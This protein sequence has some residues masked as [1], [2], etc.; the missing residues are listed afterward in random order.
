MF[1]VGTI[2]RLSRDPNTYGESIVDG[3]PNYY[4]ET[5]IDNYDNTFV[6]QRGI[7]AVKSVTG[8]DGKS[9]CPLIIISSSPHKA[10]TDDT[11][12]QDKYDPDR[13]YIRYYGDNKSSNT[14]AETNGN[15][16]LLDLLNI[17]NSGEKKIRLSEAVPIIFF[18][19]TTVDGR[20]KGNLIFQGYGVIERAELVTQYDT[21]SGEYFPNYLFHFCV[22]TMK[23]DNE[24]FDWN[25]IAKRC[26]TTLTNAQ[27]NQFAPKAWKKWVDNGKE[28][29]HLV[30]RTVASFDVIKKDEQVPQEKTREYNRLLDIYHYY[31]DNKHKF[32][33]LALEVTKKVIEENGAN[34][35]PGWITKKSGDG[36]V[37]YVLRI[38]I[39]KQSLSGLRIIV[40]GQAKCTKPD[41]KTDGKD[42][43]RTVAR[44]KRGWV[45]AFVT[46]SYFS[47]PLQQELN[48]DKYP[49]ML[50]NGKKVAEIVGTE[51]FNKKM[52]LSTYLDSLEDQYHIEKRMAE[53]II[54][55]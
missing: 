3:L 4:H 45:G 11:P 38:D 51:L 43:A 6:F 33:Y 24:G 17:Y 16:K 29:I 44:L 22:F 26:D 30:R 32:E 39:G 19:R 5:H 50:I 49:I 46:T 42:I 13:G 54:Y 36:G 12:W 25:W 10:G 9:R 31:D 8:P 1:K 14:R 40:L 18:E 52:D 41:V 2:Y 28:G 55:A 20:K 21:K 34:C 35:T 48:E 15:G 27:T 47:V 23:E 53:D 7:H 37:D